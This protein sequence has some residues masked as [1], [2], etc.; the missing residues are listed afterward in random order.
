MT[1]HWKQ[2]HFDWTDFTSDNVTVEYEFDIQGYVQELTSKLIDIEDDIA[3]GVV[4]E[5]LR[6][7]GWIVEKPERSLST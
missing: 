6:S 1:D 5:W 3:E 2:K 7:R 4:V